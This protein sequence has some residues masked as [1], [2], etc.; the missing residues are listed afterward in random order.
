MF[1][2]VRRY[3]GRSSVPSVEEANPVKTKKKINDYQ[4]YVLIAAINEP[5]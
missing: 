4:L 5:E 1:S 3:S 2:L